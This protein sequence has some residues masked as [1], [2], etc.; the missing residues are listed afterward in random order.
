L[1]YTVEE[2]AMVVS[3][4]RDLIYDEIRVGRLRSNE[5]GVRRIVARHHPLEWLDGD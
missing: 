5:A 1:A 4:G 2:A 3:I